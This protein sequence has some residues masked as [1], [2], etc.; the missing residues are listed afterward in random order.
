MHH[1][2]VSTATSEPSVCIPEP[3]VRSHG[4]KMPLL[5]VGGIDSAYTAPQT[6]HVAR[7]REN[8]VLSVMPAI[9]TS[10]APMSERYPAPN[11][12]TKKRQPKNAPAGIAAN[13]LGS[14][15]KMSP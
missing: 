5:I 12:P 3:N 14:V 10:N 11:S 9:S 1:P 6:I 15:A 13:T 4:T 8:R 7:E 2:T